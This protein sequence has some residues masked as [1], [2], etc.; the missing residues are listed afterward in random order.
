[1]IKQRSIDSMTRKANSRAKSLWHTMQDF[2]ED[3][4]EFL[5]ARDEY[6]AMF[7]DDRNFVAG[8]APYEDPSWR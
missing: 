2:F 8:T 6:H 7:K 1:M 4:P 5:D 3:A